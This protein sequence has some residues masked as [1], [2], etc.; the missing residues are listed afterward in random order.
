MTPRLSFTL[1]KC[2]FRTVSIFYV[3]AFQPTNLDSPGCRIVG[4]STVP[5]S[6]AHIPAADFNEVES[7]QISCPKL[8]I[9]YK[10]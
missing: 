2:A 9:P 1:S 3:C 10:P 4:D 6:F 5:N 7:G 8:A